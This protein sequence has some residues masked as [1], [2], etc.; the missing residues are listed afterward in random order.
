MLLRSKLDKLIIIYITAT[1]LK[2]TEF[3]FIRGAANG[4]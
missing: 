4:P 2:Y 1:E 3:Q